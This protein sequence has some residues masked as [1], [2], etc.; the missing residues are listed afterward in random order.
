MVF[1]HSVF[2][3]SVQ[4]CWQRQESSQGF[5]LNSGWGS[6]NLSTHSLETDCF[7]FLT[8]CIFHTHPCFCIASLNGIFFLGDFQQ[9]LLVFSYHIT[10]LF[11]WILL[12]QISSWISIS[13]NL[14]WSYSSWRK[15]L[16][17]HM[18][19]SHLE[20][21]NVYVRFVVLQSKSLHKT[22]SHVRQQLPI[23]NWTHFINLSTTRISSSHSIPTVHFS[24]PL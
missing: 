20:S 6:L 23:T 9:F 24:F 19:G 8:V 7:V 3:I 15:T 12:Q 14:T 22:P 4:M 16:G 10:R 17:R 1:E 5:S 21:L 11:L 13:P 2:Q 18:H